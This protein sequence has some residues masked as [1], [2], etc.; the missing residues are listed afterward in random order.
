MLILLFS[1]SE[2]NI[3]ILVLW[4]TGHLPKQGAARSLGGL[5]SAVLLGRWATHQCMAPN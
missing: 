4:Y 2:L 5:L 3:P 1:F